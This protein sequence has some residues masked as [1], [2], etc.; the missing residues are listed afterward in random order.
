MGDLVYALL[1][2]H[3]VGICNTTS[4]SSCYDFETC[5]ANV[6]A[7]KH[8]R[9]VDPPRETPEVRVEGGG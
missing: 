2:L 5:T 6:E 1:G 8:T 4:Q 7:H 3:E 9:V